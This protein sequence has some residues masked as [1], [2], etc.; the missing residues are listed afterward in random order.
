MRMTTAVLSLTGPTGALP[1]CYTDLLLERA[2][3]RDHTMAAFLDLFHHRLI[4]LFYR[5][6]EKHRPPLALEHSWDAARSQPSGR[7]S[8]H[9]DFS[10]R[11][12]SFIGLG[13]RPLRQRHD[14]PD[15]ALLYYLGFFAQ[16]HRSA[17]GLEALLR[18]FFEL[19]IQVIQFVEHKMRL[20]RQDR[21][22]LGGAGRHNVLGVDLIMGDQITD[23]G[24]K[25]RIRVGP[26]SI[27]QFRALAPDRAFFRRLVQ[28]TRL[29]VDAPLIF[30]IQLVLRAPDVPACELV[31]LSGA[32]S[33][34]GR[35]SWVKSQPTT[36]DA[37]DPIFEAGSAFATESASGA[38][39]GTERT[40]LV[41]Q[42]GH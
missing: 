5:A 27:Q 15:E 13:I 22:T 33:R 28:M 23:V 10:E 12:Y 25:F 1:L 24:S 34:L 16:R 17:I 41:P 39:V 20:S 18:D 26:L 14:F 3:E 42:S 35:D 4:S 30:D 19:P 37:D 31:S 7:Q 36:A 8:G 21:S 9:D 29:Y 11:L 2:R 40:D 32:G 38:L 6:W